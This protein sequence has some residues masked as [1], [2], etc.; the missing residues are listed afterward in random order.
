M[1]DEIHSVYGMRRRDEMPAALGIGNAL[2]IEAIVIV[3]AL[4]ALFFGGYLDFG[5]L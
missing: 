1:R 2:L 4:V 3:L 5:P